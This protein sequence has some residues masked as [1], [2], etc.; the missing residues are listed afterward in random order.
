ML[1]S[2]AGVTADLALF[3]LFIWLGAHP[4]FANAGSSAVGVSIAY[5][6]VTKYAFG[7]GRSRKTYLAFV[8]WY[9]F[10]IVTFSLLIGFTADKTGW[11][12][13][14]AK[15]ASLPF[16]FAAN[17]AFSKILFRNVPKDDKALV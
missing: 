8:A 9:A 1:G 4:S 14:V 2:L 16:S 6:L 7:T 3:E 5:L 12:P 17:F 15:I 10:S 11:Q 13:I